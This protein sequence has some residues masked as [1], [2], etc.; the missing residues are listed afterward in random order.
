MRLAV[1]FV[2]FCT[3]FAVTARARAL[4]LREV[5]AQA[6]PSVVL[7]KVSDGVDTGSGTGFFISA[8]GRV[9]T[10]HHVIEGAALVTASLSDGR[11]LEVE[12]IVADDPARDIAIIKVKGG[13]FAPLVLGESA[14]LRVGDEIAVVGSPLGLSATLSSGI[15]SAVR[16]K[17]PEQVGQDKDD[18]LASWGI[19][20]TAPISPGSSGSPIM[21]RNGEVV[22]VAVGMF[23][24]GQELNF[25]IP[26]EVV[27]SMNA[28]AAPEARPFSG[29]TPKSAV[30]RN[31]AIS[32]AVLG[33][34]LLAYLI[35]RRV[36]RR[37]A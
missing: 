14:S 29:T 11:S 1:A 17:G 7:L 9:V 36:S 25:G 13:P 12:G 6:K 4:D 2:V 33:A 18:R 24:G 23:R 20:V 15:V 3:L 32:A 16:E 31:L 5:A 19:Q 27:K 8:D 34:P 26:V 22:A 10:N 21:N 30:W 35:W 37:R 28:T